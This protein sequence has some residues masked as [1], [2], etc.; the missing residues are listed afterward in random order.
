MGGG[1]HF[2]RVGLGW[3]GGG[4]PLTRMNNGTGALSADSALSSDGGS[5]ARCPHPHLPPLPVAWAT[6]EPGLRLHRERKQG[7]PGKHR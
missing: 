1:R 3:E 7:Q 5:S 2:L 4:K 6:Q